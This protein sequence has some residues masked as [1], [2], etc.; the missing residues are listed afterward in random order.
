MKSK[1]INKEVFLNSAKKIQSKIQDEI[2]NIKNRYAEAI[3]PIKAYSKISLTSIKRVCD[4]LMIKT[5]NIVLV[6]LLSTFSKL[7][8]SM[9]S[10]IASAH[11]CQLINFV[12]WIYLICLYLLI[13]KYQLILLRFIC[14]NLP[15][16]DLEQVNVCWGP[17]FWR[18]SGL[19][20]CFSVRENW[21]KIQQKR[22]YSRL[23]MGL[24]YTI[25]SFLLRAKV[26]STV[27]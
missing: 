15:F 20:H 26:H 14:S 2:D 12:S 13:V 16:V 27:S 4:N 8:V 18:S 22:F 23:L 10:L 6:F 21:S 17:Y 1:I 25:L 11:F 3:R 9:S 5:G 19:A 7:T 24:C